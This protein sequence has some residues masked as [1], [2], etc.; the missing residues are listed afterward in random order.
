MFKLT[1]P[2][3]PLC[4]HR[5]CAFDLPWL[6]SVS[7]FLARFSDTA[8]ASSASSSTLTLAVS[9]ALRFLSDSVSIL[10]ANLSSGQA[11]R[12]SSVHLVPAPNPHHLQVLVWMLLHHS[13]LQTISWVIK[14]TEKMSK[15]N[16]MM[17]PDPVIWYQCFLEYM[18]ELILKVTIVFFLPYFHRLPEELF[19]LWPFP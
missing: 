10:P 15:I 6:W 9:F 7:S 4:F 5:L 12:P 2:V 14:I 19:S 11:L 3:C 18:Y 16:M 13:T 1:I 17:W 8:L